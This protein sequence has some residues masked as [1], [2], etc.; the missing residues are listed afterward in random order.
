MNGTLLALSRISPRVRVRDSV[1]IVY[2]IA[3]GGY[4]WIWPH[5][6]QNIWFI[7]ECNQ[8][9]TEMDISC[10]RN[11]HWAATNH[12]SCHGFVQPSSSAAG[13]CAGKGC[14]LLRQLTN[15]RRRYSVQPRG[16]PHRPDAQSAERMRSETR[17]QCKQFPITSKQTC[18]FASRI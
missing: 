16:N 2:R 8:T 17:R 3:P 11:G 9:S 14:A 4:S 13:R 18:S 5:C 15:V 12:L 7:K 10:Q 6:F 1:S